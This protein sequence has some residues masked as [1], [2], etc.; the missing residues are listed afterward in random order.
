M[1]RA[2]SYEPGAVAGQSARRLPKRV[3]IAATD[4]D[5]NE[6]GSFSKIPPFGCLTNH[7]SISIVIGVL[8][9]FLCFFLSINISLLELFVITEF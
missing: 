6:P 5:H 2:C 4:I 7:V 1:K 8:L 9:S 3:G